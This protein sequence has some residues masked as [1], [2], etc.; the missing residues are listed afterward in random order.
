MIH[1]SNDCMV[2]ILRSLRIDMMFNNLSRKVTDDRLKVGQNELNADEE[3]QRDSEHVYQ[4]L[5]FQ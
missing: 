3:R 1:I 2:N 4:N 5:L